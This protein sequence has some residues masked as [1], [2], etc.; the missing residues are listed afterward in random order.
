MC[1][2]TSNDS[3]RANPFLE[4]GE[5][6]FSDVMDR[7]SEDRGLT[8]TKRRDL[9]SD[10]RCLLRLLDLD[11]ASTPARAGALKQELK[12]LHPA[13]AEVSA[14][15]LANMKSSV[16]FGLRRVGIKNHKAKY[17]RRQTPKWKSLW[18][19]IENDQTR[20]K[21]SRL[22]G[23][24]SALGIEP[25]EVN[26]ETID[27]LRN[28]LIEESFVTNPEAAIRTTVY[29]WNRCGGDIS[30]WPSTR[31]S[32]RPVATNR[33]TYPM[34]DFPRSFVDEAANWRAQLQQS[35]PLDEDSLPHPL[36]PATVKHRMFQLRM[37]ASA[38]VHRNV[39]LDRITSLRTLVEIANFKEA[40]R[41]LLDR[42]NGNTTEA[43][44]NCATAI[45]HMARHHLKINPDD[46][47]EMDRICCR[48]RV[49]SCGLTDKNKRRLGQFDDPFNVAALLLLPAKLS[50]L[51]DRATGRK[52][53]VL[54]QMAAAIEILT[55]CPLR[56]SNLASL[57]LG[58]S[59]YWTRPGRRGRMLISISADQVK[60]NKRIDFEVPSA[61]VPL[62]QRYIDEYRSSLFH[63][64]GNWPFPG[65]NGEAK[66][67]HS[68][69]RQIK[70]VVFKHAGLT[71]NVHLFRH[72]TTKLY[73]D[74]NP[75]AHEV[76]KRVLGHRSLDTTTRFYADFQNSSAVRHFDA[77][78]LERRDESVG[79]KRR[80]LQRKS[81]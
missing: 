4:E 79:L 33:W 13:Q 46:L 40:V 11:P 32:K 29:A 75:A 8:P 48:I 73:L 41:F 50:G 6:T 27:Q 56:I 19:A 43:I 9:I 34:E 21:L 52:A 59:L 51:A 3:G 38:L 55:M 47:R 30:D 77:T 25:E 70:D 24:C 80:A 74:Q 42:N 16:L 1:N 2:D 39:P 81:K 72:I 31:L 26:D 57:E 68:L 18:K 7:L 45:K 37:F 60:N 67:A 14:K 76:V 36:R 71:V 20:W 22:F 78:I 17:A 23:Y 15:R 58:A 35:D 5:P 66:K 12:A 10:I 65:R 61:S 64:P 49:R 28:A 53:A 54:M 44:Y 63:D 62:I 69:S